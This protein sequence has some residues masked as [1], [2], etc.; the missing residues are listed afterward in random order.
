MNRRRLA[1]CVLV[2]LAVC[3]ALLRR[4]V[5]R[6]KR[7][8]LSFEGNLILIF[9]ALL[10]VTDLTMSGA[11]L[12]L[13]QIDPPYSPAEQLVGNLLAGADPRGIVWLNGVSWWVHL[14]TLVSFLNLLPVSKHFHILTS[15][16]KVSLRNLKQQG[17]PRRI[18]WRDLAARGWS[19]GT[20]P[21]ATTWKSRCNPLWAVVRT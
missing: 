1:L 11:T 14:L 21:L 4:L 5:I 19:R 3:Y 10:M 20:R 16:P 7:I 18:D 17:R 15:V 2:L 8:K 12:M 9:I 6:P 13:G